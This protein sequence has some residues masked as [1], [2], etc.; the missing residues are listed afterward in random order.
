MK[1]S[2]TKLRT[3]E[4]LEI[5]DVTCVV[6][7]NLG[8]LLLAVRNKDGDILKLF[9]NEIGDTPYA[10]KE[11]IFYCHEFKGEFSGEYAIRYFHK[12]VAIMNDNKM[13]NI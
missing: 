8:G 9:E 5:W 12:P 4:F 10:L 6:Y 7:P 3:F 11:A 13:V 1:R 2:P